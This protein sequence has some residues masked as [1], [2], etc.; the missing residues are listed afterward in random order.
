ML[1]AV[2]M[3]IEVVIEALLGGP[4]VAT[5]MSE[6][7]TTSDR[8]SGAKEWMKNKLKALSQLQR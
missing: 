3:A 6:S 5:T 7:T 2:G 4:S 8:R 1:T